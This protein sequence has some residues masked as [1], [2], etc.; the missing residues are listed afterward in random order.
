MPDLRTNESSSPIFIVGCPRSGTSLLRDLLHAHSRLAFPTESHFLPA[1]FQAY[2]DPRS[3]REARGLARRILNLRWVR[4]WNLPLR[5]EDFSEDRS[6]AVVAQR[7]YQTFAHRHGKARWGDKTP[8][9]ITTLPVLRKIF[10]QC[11][12]IHLYR[13]GRDVALSWLRVGLDPRNIFVAAHTWK[14]FVEQGRRDGAEMPAQMYL[15]LRYESLLARPQ[16]TMREICDFIGESFEPEMFAV[17]RLR[18][19]QRQTRIGTRDFGI[20]H[21]A[22]VTTNSGK[23]KTQ[24]SPRQVAIVESVAGDLLHSLG[25]EISAAPRRISR[26][27]AALY[28]THHACGWVV[29]RLNTKDFW[30]WFGSFA[31][32]TQARI[33]AR[34]KVQGKEA[35][36]TS[37]PSAVGVAR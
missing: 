26:A 15:E 31:A 11:K 5:P 22:L 16:Q 37:A 25:Y 9:Y 13:D 27:R 3:A 28:W 8:Q 18:R 7:L 33:L 14:K 29:D 6:F 35:C 30:E 2:G 20:A 17:H 21:T 10:P 4:S 23:W 1:F 34:G 36:Q 19:N 32:M 12:I 24:L